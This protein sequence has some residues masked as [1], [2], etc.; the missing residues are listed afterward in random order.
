[1]SGQLKNNPFEKIP[2]W[3]NKTKI[4]QASEVVAGDI[5]VIPAIMDLYFV[6]EVLPRI[7]DYY[8]FSIF[9]LDRKFIKIVSWQPDHF[10]TVLN[11]HIL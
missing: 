10:L 3:G 8:Y 4:I 1:M 6:V 11:S 9:Q 2:S 7:H 5:V